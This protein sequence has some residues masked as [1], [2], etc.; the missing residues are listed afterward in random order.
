MYLAGVV[1][2][3]LLVLSGGIMAVKD[4]PDHLRWASDFM[5]T[6]YGYESIAKNIFLNRQRMDCSKKICFFPDPA[7]YLKFKGVEGDIFTDYYAMLG[8]FLIFRTAAFVVLYFKA[9]QRR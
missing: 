5:Y 6:K 1:I 4:I 9:S 7:N 2:S 3:P 8:Y